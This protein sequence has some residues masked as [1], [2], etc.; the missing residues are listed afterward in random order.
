[1]RTR[2][3]YQTAEGI[4]GGRTAE[5]SARSHQQGWG[6]LKRVH[7]G[8]QGWRKEGWGF[9]YRALERHR[10]SCPCPMQTRERE[11]LP[12]QAFPQFQRPLL[13]EPKL[14]LTGEVFPGPSYILTKLTQKGLSEKK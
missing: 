14:A 8:L 3:S 2:S 9:R 12:L 5:G 10:K 11:A 6:S 13:T 7:P 4:A 1:M